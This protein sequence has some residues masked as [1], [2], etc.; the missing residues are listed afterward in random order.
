ML[1]ADL[2]LRS[3]LQ[4]CPN[5]AREALA[6]YSPGIYA[7]LR[8]RFK[9]NLARETDDGRGLFFFLLAGLAVVLLL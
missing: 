2:A 8:C 7:C 5:C 9:R 1:D 3:S 4:T 6:H